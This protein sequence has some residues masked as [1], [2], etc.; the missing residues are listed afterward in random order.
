MYVKFCNNPRNNYRA[1]DCV[2]RAISAA[3]GDTWE[4]IYA[5]LSAE[6]YYVGEWG[7]S[8]GVWDSYL[9]HRGFKRYICPNDCPSCY[10]VADFAADHNKGTYILGTGH[11]AVTIKDGNWLDS[12]DSGSEI[13]IYYY[14]KE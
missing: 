10:S 2:I 4:K 1:G 8:N 9:R 11:H 12:W 13:P 6:G 14:T 3:T 5:E 7:N